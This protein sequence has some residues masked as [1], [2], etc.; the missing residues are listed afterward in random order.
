M[1][2]LMET[3]AQWDAAS[4]S[5]AELMEEAFR[6][7]TIVFAGSHKQE[8]P[9]YD[10]FL[11]HL[12]TASFAVNI[13]QNVLDKDELKKALHCQLFMFA[14]IIYLT[15]QKPIIDKSLIT[16][17]QDMGDHK[18][19]YVVDKTIN[20]RLAE[21]SHFVKVI[22][23]LKDA[24]KLFGDDDHIYLNSALKLVKSMDK[25][26]SVHWI[27]GFHDQEHTLNIRL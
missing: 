10:F 14:L 8:D 15:Q 3:Y 26:G 24:S 20:T 17:Y 12:V 23:A 5:P 18:W 25:R 9:Q 13:L 1:K 21:D 11:L 16:S 7:Y 19:E 2:I 6:T 4:K 22:R 27:G